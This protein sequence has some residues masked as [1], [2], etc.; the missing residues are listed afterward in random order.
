[1]EPI[2]ELARPCAAGSLQLNSEREAMH[3]KY[4]AGIVG[5][6]IATPLHAQEAKQIIVGQVTRVETLPVCY[7]GA[8]SHTVVQAAKDLGTGARHFALLFKFGACAFIKNAVIRADR[9]IE[10]Y[11]DNAGTE[12]YYPMSEFEFH[13]IGSDGRPEGPFWGITPIPIVRPGFS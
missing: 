12:E 13:L 4:A 3:L 1:M 2:G 8:S 11:K 6:L 9:V 7:H 10:S 5:I